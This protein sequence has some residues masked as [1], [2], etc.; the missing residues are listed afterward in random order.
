MQ[1]EVPVGLA[2]QSGAGL[3]IALHCS[4]GQGISVTVS[5]PGSGIFPFPLEEAFQNIREETRKK[6]ISFSFQAA[7]Q[8]C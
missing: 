4:D 2:L 6:N 8:N 3:C 1:P 7:K 5:A